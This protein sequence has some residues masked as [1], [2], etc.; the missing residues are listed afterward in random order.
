[1]KI[2]DLIDVRNLPSRRLIRADN[3]EVVHISMATGKK[4]R[5][6]FC[7]ITQCNRALRWPTTIRMFNF[8]DQH[9]LCS[10]CASDSAEFATAFSEYKEWRK[11]SDLERYWELR[12][13]QAERVAN[14][15]WNEL[16]RKIDQT[17][18]DYLEELVEQKFTLVP[19]RLCQAMPG[20]CFRCGHRFIN[21]EIKTC[22]VCGAERGCREYAVKGSLY[23]RYHGGYLKKG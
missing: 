8:P 18:M 21:Y 12:M 20:I 14:H 17:I 15:S 6:Q 19:V 23:C 11:R 2:S 13:E 16:G 3:S 9:N 5:F 1:M 10:R 7:Y 4:G 22:P